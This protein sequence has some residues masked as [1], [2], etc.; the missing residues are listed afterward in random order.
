MA[1]RDYWSFFIGSGGV[2]RR[3]TKSVT[4]THERRNWWNE[5]YYLDVYGSKSY[6]IDATGHPPNIL[7]NLNW[8]IHGGSLPPLDSGHELWL[9]KATVS[10]KRLAYVSGSFPWGVQGPISGPWASSWGAELFGYT[11]DPNS[12]N[13]PDSNSYSFLAMKNYGSMGISRSVQTVPYIPALQVIGELRE[14]IPTIPGSQLLER[15]HRDSP[16]DV[17][18]IL[19]RGGATSAE[20]AAL[21]KVFGKTVAGEFLNFVFG[22]LPTISDIQNIVGVLSNESVA[23]VQASLDS[24][25]RKRF[26]RER[27]LVN[28][29]V[30]THQERWV[31]PSLDGSTIFTVDQGLETLDTTGTRRVWFEGVFDHAV[32]AN[33]LTSK[34]N[35]LQ[36]KL[37]LTLAMPL[38]EGLWELIPYSWLVDWF[39]N[40]GKMLSN[41]STFQREGL[42]MP[43]GYVM[44][45]TDLL[46]VDI[47]SG[48][49]GGQSFYAPVRRTTLVKQRLKA[50]P[51]GFGLKVSDLSDI[52]KA[53]LA[54][55][56]VSRLSLPSR[57]P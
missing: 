16:V 33:E 26:H 22:I 42:S 35:E 8:L 48:R 49:V 45:E 1:N 25:L 29:T 5:V 50:T 17:N 52:Q 23:R 46:D 27:V 3:A 38:V 41:A 21:T 55:L 15:F 51:F 14:G 44:A 40:I 39:T 20:M 31:Y 57:L 34:L 37:G 47:W 13:V 30:K 32:W 56:G 28:E 6:I 19:K 2:R 54:A 9:E 10:P 11:D 12:G 43:Y 7:G 36:S 18:K 53:I 24:Q 4:R